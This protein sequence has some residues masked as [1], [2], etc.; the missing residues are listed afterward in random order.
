M[1]DVPFGEICRST[2]VL[3]LTCKGHRATWR[4]SGS[5]NA[6]SHARRRCRFSTT[7][8][9]TLPCAFAAGRDAGAPSSS[10]PTTEKAT[11]NRI[12]TAAEMNFDDASCIEAE[13]NGAGHEARSAVPELCW[14]V[15]CEAPPFVATNPQLTDALP[16]RLLV[17]SLAVDDGEAVLPLAAP[18]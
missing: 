5:G 7:R 1:A 17:R 2:A 11:A 6:C 10:T 8:Y 13:L 15:G 4:A 14:E 9:F 12:E 3:R 18:H 16:A